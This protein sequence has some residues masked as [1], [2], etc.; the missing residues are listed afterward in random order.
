MATQPGQGTGQPSLVCVL[1][2]HRLTRGRG[3]DPCRVAGVLHLTTYTI[4]STPAYRQWAETLP[5]F[6]VMLANPALTPSDLAYQS[7]AK[8][9]ARL[10]LVSPVVFP[11]PY[12][13]RHRPSAE[14]CGPSPC[15]EEHGTEQVQQ[16]VLQ[17]PPSAATRQ[18]GS[19]A[20]ERVHLAVQSLRD[21][22][23]P[24]KAAL[25][26]PSHAPASP[27]APPSGCGRSVLLGRACST[28]CGTVPQGDHGARLPTGGPTHN[29]TPTASARDR[30]GAKGEERGSLSHAAPCKANADKVAL[31]SG[32]DRLRCL[33]GCRCIG[34]GEPLPQLAD[35]AAGGKV[36]SA[37]P[38]VSL[39]GGTAEDPLEITVD[40]GLCRED[41]DP[42]ETP[43]VL[44][45]SDVEKD[46]DAE[47]VSPVV[48]SACTL[49]CGDVQM[50]RPL[51]LLC[52]WFLLRSGHS[53]VVTGQR[54]LL[55]AD[56]GSIPPAV[57]NYLKLF[58]LILLCDPL[59]LVQFELVGRGRPRCQCATE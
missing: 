25:Q 24:D 17:T 14:Q 46:F 59:W 53:N 21:C 41:L 9:V 28:I 56:R 36:V 30:D 45:S 51:S 5:G 22:T 52:Q 38:F 15:T 39:S 4:S 23:A 35:D 55:R 58:L 7:S 27:S 33:E 13:F 34:A 18:S 16:D 32:G 31:A 42:G 2:G 10:N 57:V 54:G 6:Q 44:L 37:V 8:H 47:I 40:R 1:Q 43:P 48:L 26:L 49:D 3:R 12:V 29:N 19:T 50:W 11:L 20:S